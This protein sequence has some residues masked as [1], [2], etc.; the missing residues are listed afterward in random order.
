MK[1]MG[2]TIFVHDEEAREI[3]SAWSK[4]YFGDHVETV[5]VFIDGTWLMK[6]KGL[7]P[8]DFEAFAALYHA[9]N[10]I[11]RLEARLSFNIEKE[12][13]LGPY[14]IG[15]IL[16]SIVQERTNIPVF[17]EISFAWNGICLSE[18]LL[19]SAPEIPELKKEG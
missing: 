9:N 18:Y 7:V 14:Q 13:Y 10:G 1:D 15:R 12:T 11:G 17:G 5:L 4:E 8:K 19:E 2:K 6:L 16:A 3:I